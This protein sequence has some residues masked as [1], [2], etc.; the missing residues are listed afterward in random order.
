MTRKWGVSTRWLAPLARAFLG[1]AGSWVGPACTKGSCR[2]LLVSF[3]LPSRA[4][5]DRSLAHL[6]IRCPKRQQSEPSNW[7]KRGQSSAGDSRFWG[8]QV[9]FIPTG[10]PRRFFNTPRQPRDQSCPPFIES[11]QFSTLLSAPIRTSRLSKTKTNGRRNVRPNAPQ[12]H[13]LRTSTSCQTETLR[14]SFRYAL[15]VP[16][17]DQVIKYDIP[18]LFGLKKRPVRLSILVHPATSGVGLRLSRDSS[19]T[20]WHPGNQ[21][22][23]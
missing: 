3:P 21:V 4:Q 15:R 18:G 5:R 8:R 9:P 16:D 11:P 17:I 2:R 20:Q 14:P 19:S 7:K 13:V 1:G 23:S 12:R 6:K 22:H 10:K